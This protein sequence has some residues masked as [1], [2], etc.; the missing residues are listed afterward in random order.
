MSG[1]YAGL[2]GI[3]ACWACSLSTWDQPKPDLVVGLVSQQAITSPETRTVLGNDS[4]QSTIFSAMK[5]HCCCQHCFLRER[6][7][8]QWEWNEAVLYKEDYED[9]TTLTSLKF[10]DTSREIWRLSKSSCLLE[11]WQLAALCALVNVMNKTENTDAEFYL[12]TQKADTWLNSSPQS[13]S[14]LPHRT[15]SPSSAQDIFL[16]CNTTNK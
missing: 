10:E 5:R 3:L 16:Q 12:W 9:K 6:M 15:K 4:H 14:H 1:P 13:C 2:C 8:R 7:T 11:R